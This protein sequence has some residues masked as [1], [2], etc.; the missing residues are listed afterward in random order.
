M[1]ILTYSFVTL[2]LATAA[3]AQT[4]A[5]G[6]QQPERRVASVNTEPRVD[7]TNMPRPMD[8]WMENK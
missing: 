7:V 1:R 2:L 5:A 8:G 3:F 6:G 4:P